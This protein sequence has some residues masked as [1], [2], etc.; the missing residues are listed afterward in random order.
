MKVSLRVL[1]RVFRKLDPEEIPIEK[2]GKWMLRIRPLKS[3]LEKTYTI[4]RNRLDV[5]LESNQTKVKLYKG[6]K[7]TRTK[8]PKYDYDIK[9]LRK[10]LLSRL[11]KSV[12]DKII[13]KEYTE[14]VN[15]NAITAF[16]ESGDIGHDEIMPFVIDKSSY[17]LNVARHRAK[18]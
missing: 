8:I 3:Y 17:R 7:V 1:E 15:E 14:K 5:F 9:K 16:L 11:K 10:F 6:V 18:K 13:Y 2:V 12:V 4:L